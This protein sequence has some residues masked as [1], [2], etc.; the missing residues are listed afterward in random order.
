MSSF[1]RM[2]LVPADQIE[3][4]L[5]PSKNIYDLAKLNSPVSFLRVNDLETELKD[6]LESDLDERSKSKLYSQALRK[7]LTFKKFALEDRFIDEGKAVTEK[8][9]I[10]KPK[11]KKI[12]NEYAGIAEL[13]K[14]K[15]IKRKKKPK[16]KS[17]Q[18][19]KSQTSGSIDEIQWL[20]YDNP[21]L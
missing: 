11:R 12:I 9:K 2:K 4:T 1:K 8:K 7:Y 6:I 17:I 21:Q 5:N 18:P 15:K 10:S 19:K 13:F 20:A 16:V 14:E 3:M